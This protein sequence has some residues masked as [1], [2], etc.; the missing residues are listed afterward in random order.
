MPREPFHFDFNEDADPVDELHRLRVAKTKHY[1]TI[2]ALM[3]SRRSMPST[4][5]II[6]RLEARIAEKKGAKVTMSRRPSPS[7][8]RKAVAQA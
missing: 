5:E 8:R 1:K 4:N 7:R 2:E 3:E 6:A